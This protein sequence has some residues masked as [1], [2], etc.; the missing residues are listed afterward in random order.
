MNVVHLPTA[1]QKALDYT[2]GRVT[3]DILEATT[4]VWFKHEMEDGDEAAGPIYLAVEGRADLVP[5]TRGGEAEW[6]SE[7]LARSLASALGVE[8]VWS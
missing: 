7:T 8:V 5:L 2:I 3:N 1:E 6:H 4:A